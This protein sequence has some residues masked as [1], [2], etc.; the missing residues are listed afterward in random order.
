MVAWPIAVGFAAVAGGCAYVYRA[1]AVQEAVV[2]V[3]IL[4]VV[5]IGV[6]VV[7]VVVVSVVVV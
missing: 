3:W 2:A 5:A 4:I 6:A 1:L 7:V